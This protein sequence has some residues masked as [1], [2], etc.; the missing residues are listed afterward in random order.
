MLS[1]IYSSAPIQTSTTSA[2]LPSGIKSYAQATSAAKV[3][4]DTMNQTDFLTLF[5]TQLKNQNPLDPVKNEAFV[6]Q[7]AQFSQLEATTN[8]SSSMNS[9]VQ[10]L[11]NDKILNGANLIG[12]TISVPGGSAK[13]DG[14]EPV[15][16]AVNLPTG[17][18]G[19]RFDVYDAKGAPIRSQVLGPQLSGDMTWF[20][21]GKDESGNLM[22]IGNYRFQATAL[23]Q[24]NLNK[25]VVS[26]LNKIVSVSKDPASEVMLLEVEDGQRIDLA[27]ISRIGA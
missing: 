9:L 23:N 27:T 3:K 10:S 12:R 13:L 6:A 11:G 14:E 1:T 7:L 20:W 17:A 15:M 22:P 4:D 26:T 18:E 19:I 5:T 16:A 21:D 8:M 24:G 25:P 2:N